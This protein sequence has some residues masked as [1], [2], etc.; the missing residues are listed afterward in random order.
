MLVNSTLKLENEHIE[1]EKDMVY[2]T[3]AYVGTALLVII[4]VLVLSGKDI[5]DF[6]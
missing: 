3:G 5:R 4:A 2:D 6:C 1:C